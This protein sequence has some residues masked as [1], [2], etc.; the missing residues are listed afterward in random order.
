MLDPIRLQLVSVSVAEPNMESEIKTK[1]MVNK[2]PTDVT[3]G[4]Q[5][6]RRIYNEELLV[7]EH[8][9]LESKYHESHIEHYTGH[10]N[11]DDSERRQGVCR[12]VEW[13]Y[14]QEVHYWEG[15][16]QN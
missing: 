4:P 16:P 13:F 9:R 8:P 6:A 5:T 12:E 14:S 3:I 1:T 2:L 7:F 11:S 10:S 15:D